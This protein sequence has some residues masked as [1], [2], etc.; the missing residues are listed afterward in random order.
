MF[1]PTFK[2]ICIDNLNTIN[3]STQKEEDERAERRKKKIPHTTLDG[4]KE[5]G[6]LVNEL[7]TL[8]TYLSL[9]KSSIYVRTAPAERWM[10][11][12]E[13]DKIY[14]YIA[15]RATQHKVIT[16]PGEPFWQDI[17]PFAAAKSNNWHHCQEGNSRFLH[18][19]WDR[20]LFRIM[21][22]S[23]TAT[24][25]PRILEAICDKHQYD[26]AYREIKSN[27]PDWQPSYQR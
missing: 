18:Y 10:L 6:V 16:I 9:F 24:L 15:E 26:E 2:V 4:F 19:H 13:V 27:E 25:H 20:F 11:T 8:M 17:R 12:A 22:F 3:A 5:N 7:E 23:K 14:E 1:P 21:C